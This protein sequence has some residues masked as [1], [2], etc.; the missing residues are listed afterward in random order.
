MI[1]FTL[2][3]LSIKMQCLLCAKPFKKAMVLSNPSR[4]GKLLGLMATLISFRRPGQFIHAVYRDICHFFNSKHLLKKF[5]HTLLFPIQKTKK[6]Q[7]VN[8][9][10]P[11]SL[12][13]LF[14]KII[15]KILPNR[16]KLGLNKCIA[17]SCKLKH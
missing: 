2:S 3:L 7:T 13:N 9:Y 8:D 12:C 15:S 4:S 5:N 14:C 16:L 1:F 10:Q 17:E 6:V 11:I